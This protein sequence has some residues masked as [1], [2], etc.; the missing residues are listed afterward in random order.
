MYKRF[1]QYRKCRNSVITY[2]GCTGYTLEV[3]V[4]F[5]YWQKLQILPV[6]SHIG[7][8]STGRV[9]FLYI[10]HSC[11][12]LHS[13]TWWTFLLS[14]FYFTSVVWFSSKFYIYALSRVCYTLPDTNYSVCDVNLIYAFLTCMFILYGETS[15]SMVISLT[16]ARF[17][18]SVYSHCWASSC[19]ILVIFSCR[20]VHPAFVHIRTLWLKNQTPVIFSN[21]F[22]KYWSIYIIFGTQNKQWVSDVY[23]CNCEF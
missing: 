4:S 7:S 21:D 12:S 8:T 1:S 3:S 20:E 9:Y 18:L 10:D 14:I 17:L 2:Y 6:T 5:W 16:V 22:N 11:F 13:C 15:F 23:M 19:Y